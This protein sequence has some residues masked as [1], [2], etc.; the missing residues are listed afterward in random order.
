MTTMSTPYN[1]SVVIPVPATEQSP[2]HKLIRK[3]G[4]LAL[5]LLLAVSSLI[6]IA[7]LAFHVYVAWALSHPPVASLVSNPMLAK[8]LTYSEVTF[9]SADEKTLVDGWWIPADESRQTVVLSHG[10]GANR[11]E[12]WVPMYDLADL[13][14]SLKYNVLMFDYGFASAAHSTPATGGRI[15]SQQLI[16]ALQ[17]ARKQGN[18]ELIIWGFSMGAGTALQAAL[19]S[20][21]VDAMILDSTFLPDDDTLYHNIRNQINIPKYPSVSLIRL[22]FPLMSGTRLEQIPSAQVQQTAFDFPI[23]LIHGTADD[24]A[25]TYISENVAKA[26]T[27]ALSQLWIVPGAIHEMIYRTHTQEYVQRTTSFLDRVHT[28]VLAKL[29]TTQS[30]TA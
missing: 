6:V 26:Q 30:I 25:P 17:Y 15:E 23:L 1:G 24:K 10:Y 18:D 13:L 16:G 29:Q 3:L 14:H 19:Q 22:F 4:R 12:S 2:D 27:N 7:F 5:N 11:E 21:P 9:P 8:N 28:E 20:E